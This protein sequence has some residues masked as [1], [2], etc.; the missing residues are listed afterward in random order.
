MKFASSNVF[1]TNFKNFCIINKSFVSLAA[2]FGISILLSPILLRV[3][4]V[5]YISKIIA[6]FSLRLNST[7]FLYIFLFYFA[8]Y[9]LF[10]LPIF[11]SG[12]SVSG[13]IVSYIYTVFLGSLFGTHTG[14]F[15]FTFGIKGFMHC[16]SV[17][18]PSIIIFSISYILG[19]RESQTFSKMIGRAF[20]TEEK[21]NFYFDFKLYC[22]R[23]AFIVILSSLAA[24][25]FSL[26]AYFVK[27]I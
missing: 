3:P 14:Y 11:L 7:Y 2:V 25:V 10:I 9:L 26:C 24:L 22:K 18:F 19:S 4:F 21:M 6:E 8:C 17:I 1:L 5:F 16:L 23:F 27:V 15:Y 13:F 12:I 20:S